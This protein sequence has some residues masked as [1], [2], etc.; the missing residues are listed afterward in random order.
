MEHVH[1]CLTTHAC[2]TTHT[3]MP[4]ILPPCSPFAALP[5]QGGAGEEAALL[6]LSQPGHSEQ[7]HTSSSGATA[8]QEGG[9][10]EL[11]SHALHPMSPDR[12]TPDR[13]SSSGT[14]GVTS[15]LEANGLQHRPSDDAVLAPVKSPRT[16][17]PLASCRSSLEAQMEAIVNGMLPS[18]AS[19]ASSISQKHHH[20]H[21]AEGGV[22]RASTP[23]S[24][25]P[26]SHA[27]LSSGPS[28]EQLL[29]D[30][31]CCSSNTFTAATAG[32]QPRASPAPTDHVLLA[33]TLLG[34]PAAN[35]RSH[36]AAHPL[37]PALLGPPPGRPH[38]LPGLEHHMR[39]DAQPAGMPSILLPAADPSHPPHRLAPLGSPE[40]SEQ[41]STP[42]GQYTL[43]PGASCVSVASSSAPSSLATP[44]SLASVAT[45]GAVSLGV[46]ASVRTSADSAFSGNTSGDIGGTSMDNV[47]S[48][49]PS[50]AVVGLGGG[51]HPPPT[52]SAES[53]LALPVV[54]PE[55]SSV[56]GLSIDSTRPSPASVYGHVGGPLFP[57]RASITPSPVGP[58]ITPQPHHSSTPHGTAKRTSGTGQSPRVHYSS[59]KRGG[60]VSAKAAAAR[61][62]RLSRLS[63]STGSSFSGEELGLPAGRY[64]PSSR[65]NMGQPL[66]TVPDEAD[67]VMTALPSQSMEMGNTR[68]TRDNSQ[69][70]MDSSFH[71]SKA[72]EL[73]VCVCVCVCLCV[74]LCVYSCL[75]FTLRI[76]T[77][78]VT[79]LFQGHAC[80]CYCCLST[81]CKV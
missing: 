72:S 76:L 26:S 30:D 81:P 67:D 14:K 46:G 53:S 57:D 55:P 54:S 2:N 66:D 27:P 7:H 4:L 19:P 15:P 21:H 10:G 34:R 56:G 12:T 63:F 59:S 52:M 44:L 60:Q 39:L 3:Y 8:Q 23:A 61:A 43:D 22:R 51:I 64:P 40:G 9:A 80:C 1:L 41:L 31:S 42:G 47:M 29:H 18:N 48:A 79:V 50:S 37:T 13:K 71:S 45:A 17:T 24:E 78:T 32:R 77:L 36:P 16:S 49:Q 74:C 25:A 28:K 62:Q 38:R 69:F 20:H 35:H 70:G 11:R 68:R 73:G 75:C 65:S 33:P 6:R 58:C 5:L